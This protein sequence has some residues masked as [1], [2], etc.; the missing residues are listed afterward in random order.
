MLVLPQPSPLTAD[1]GLRPSLRS[2][3]LPNG[4]YSS[5]GGALPRGPVSCPS[6]PAEDTRLGL[7]L[8]EWLWAEKQWAQPHKG[9]GTAG[10]GLQ[11]GGAQ[12]VEDGTVRVL[13]G[14]LGGPRLLHSGASMILPVGPG[15]QKLLW[16]GFQGWAR[17]SGWGPGSVPLM[18]TSPYTGC[19]ACSSGHGCLLLLEGCA[20]PGPGLSHRGE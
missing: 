13:L 12:L 15:Q 4:H 20:R 17:R 6:L 11:E 10:Q 8:K 16:P 14:L 9:L 5:L 18:S 7:S 2:L 1:Q 19:P 3:Q